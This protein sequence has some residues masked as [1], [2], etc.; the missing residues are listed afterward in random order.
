V[1]GVAKFYG[2]ELPAEGNMDIG[3]RFRIWE[4]QAIQ[5]L[6]EKYG[7]AS[8]DIEES[9][10]FPRGNRGSIR[11]RVQGEIVSRE[12]FLRAARCQE[13]GDFQME[14]EPLSSEEAFLREFLSQVQALRDF[15]QAGDIAAVSEMGASIEQFV[16]E[17]RL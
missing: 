17:H 15:A 14:I 16:T 11:Y 1:P 6:Q 9:R 8:E 10:A 13:G 12:E 7:Y 4:S 5:I 2:T 3:S